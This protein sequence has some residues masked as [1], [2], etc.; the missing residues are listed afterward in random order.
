M[1]QQVPKI[2][3]SDTMQAQGKKKKK[4]SESE[5]KREKGRN[6]QYTYC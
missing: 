6:T 3:S 1:P 4:E 2:D 5:N